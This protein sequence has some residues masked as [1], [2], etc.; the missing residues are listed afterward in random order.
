MYP[1]VI[2]STDSYFIATAKEI[3][4]DWMGSCANVI[5]YPKYIKI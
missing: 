1:V 3:N 5:F 4:T 2:S